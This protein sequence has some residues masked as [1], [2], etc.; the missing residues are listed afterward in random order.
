MT[1]VKKKYDLRGLSGTTL[2]A[3]LYQRRQPEVAG[4]LRIVRV[5]IFF[6][7]EFMDL[8]YYRRMTWAP[9][10]LVLHSPFQH[11]GPRAEFTQLGHEA[12][13]LRL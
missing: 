4:V 11:P 9:P 7:T 6:K 1:S 3:R 13:Q 5:G 12:L 8:L 10:P 2:S